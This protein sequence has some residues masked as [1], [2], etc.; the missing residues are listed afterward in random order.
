MIKS[1]LLGQSSTLSVSPHELEF[2]LAIFVN[3]TRAQKDQQL[4][5]VQKVKSDHVDFTRRRAFA[6]RS[7]AV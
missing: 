3:V 4:R 1:Y 7:R 6:F 2:E 5:H